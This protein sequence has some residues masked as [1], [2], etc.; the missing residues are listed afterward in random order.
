MKRL[1][2]FLGNTTLSLWLLGA[3]V[4]LFITGSVISDMNFSF[5]ASMNDMPLQE[6]VARNMT[7]NWLITWWLPLLLVD[8]ALLAL[9]T[10]V[11]T[12][13][14]IRV[15]IPRFREE[16]SFK[17]FHALMPSLVHVFFLVIM[18][19]HLMTFTLGSWQRIPLVQGEEISIGTDKNPFLVESIHHEYYPGKSNLSNRI[20]QTHVL[21][22]GSDKNID[23]S[24][25]NS[26]SYGG[27]H[28]QL[29]ME[30]ARKR[31]QK[32]GHRDVH[33]GGEETCNKSEVYHVHKE[34]IRKTPER[35][36]YVLAIRDPGL[37]TILTGF[38]FILVM[39][40]WYFIFF[41]RYRNNQT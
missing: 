39:M 3:G 10:L 17:V 4:V 6:W 37:Y 12:I 38:V 29:D 11:C 20:K 5:F 1:W 16:R 18:A 32:L 35:K 15:L 25:L 23:I 2:E 9:N 19:G 8:L 7:D 36:L 14:R 13:E 26:V 31:E 21:L 24:Y 33:G 41:F 34:K 40:T 22:K 27:Y 30:K 28:L